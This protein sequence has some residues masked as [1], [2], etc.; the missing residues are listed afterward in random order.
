[1]ESAKV[2]G[3]KKKKPDESRKR[4]HV[5]LPYTEKESET[6]AKVIRKHN[7]PVTMRPVKTLKRMCWFIPK[8]NKKG[9]K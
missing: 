1:M 2:Q 9:S 7:V 4:P 6:I 5:V 8:T 3:K